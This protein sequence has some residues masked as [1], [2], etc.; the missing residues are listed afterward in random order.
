MDEIREPLSRIHHC[1]TCGKYWCHPNCNRRR[2]VTDAACPQCDDT[3]STTDSWFIGW[4]Y[5]DQF[6]AFVKGTNLS[7]KK[8]G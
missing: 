6:Q 5:P 4:F 8:R 2:G 3:T 7:G 1:R